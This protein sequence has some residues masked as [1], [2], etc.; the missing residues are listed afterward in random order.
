MSS[1]VVGF[2]H[3]GAKAYAPENTLEAFAL[4]L[5]LGASG[6]E[7]DVWLTA[8]GVPVLDHDGV[9]KGRLRSKPISAVARVDL[10]PHIPT[11]DE[12]LAAT[13]PVPLSLDVKD[14][15]AFSAI[16]EVHRR[17]RERA[18]HLLYL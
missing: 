13:P 5:R 6:L 17:Y 4:A 1:V 3:R 18:G 16:I 2:A 8:D 11:L 7:S 12:M 15:E 9:V 14:P 10:P